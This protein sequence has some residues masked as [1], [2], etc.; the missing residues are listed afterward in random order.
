MLDTISLSLT[1]LYLYSLASMLDTVSLSLEHG[2]S[3]QELASP[4][5]GGGSCL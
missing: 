1:V 4:V 3:I 2:K 5:M